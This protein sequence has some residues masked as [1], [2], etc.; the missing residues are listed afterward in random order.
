MDVNGDGL[1]DRV[2]HHNYKTNEYGYW[3][4]LNTGKSFGEFENWGSNATINDQYLFDWSGYSSYVDVNGDG[5]P[6]RVHHYN[7]KTNIFGYWV[8][9][10]TGKK[11]WRISEL[12]K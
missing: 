1:P 6:D 11:F 9:L 2:H 4:Q 3:V 8:Q 7:Y 10:N 5:L 12:G